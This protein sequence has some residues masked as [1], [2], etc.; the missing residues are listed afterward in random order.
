MNEMSDRNAWN[1]IIVLSIMEMMMTMRVFIHSLTSSS[2]WM[3][4]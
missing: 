2:K 3:E 1:K 4:V